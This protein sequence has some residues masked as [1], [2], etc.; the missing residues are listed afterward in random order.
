[1]ATALWTPQFSACDDLFISLKVRF[2]LS[3][4]RSRTCFCPEWRVLRRQKLSLILWMAEYWPLER[5][6][7]SWFD[8]GS[9]RPLLVVEAFFFLYNPQAKPTAFLFTVKCPHV[10]HCHRDSKSCHE[11]AT[12][13]LCEGLQVYFS[14]IYW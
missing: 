10:P 2:I 6:L 8:L 14:T 11:V 1:M 5:K 12:L 3:V 13:R 9:P 7:V 4:Y